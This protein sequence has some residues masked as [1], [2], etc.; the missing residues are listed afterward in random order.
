MIALL[1]R[2]MIALDISFWKESREALLAVYF[3]CS[4]LAHLRLR[5]LQ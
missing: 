1:L 5:Y 3:Q 2:A 4:A